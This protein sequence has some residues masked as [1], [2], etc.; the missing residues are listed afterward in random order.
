MLIP[1]WLYLL[2]LMIPWSLTGLAVALEPWT[3]SNDRFASRLRGAAAAHDGPL[4]EAAPQRQPAAM[5]DAQA[6]WPVGWRR[7]TRGWER[8]DDW[9]LSSESVS[10]GR[11]SETNRFRHRHPQ[12]INDWIQHGRDRELAWARTGT[13]W[14]RSIHPIA[15]AMLLVGTALMIAKISQRRDL[16]EPLSA[17]GTP[18]E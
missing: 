6:V 12:S 16:G 11:R 4:A 2:V 1:R 10:A 14:V 7:T 3:G 9:P 13:Q 8:A 15:L 17:T 18:A 5:A